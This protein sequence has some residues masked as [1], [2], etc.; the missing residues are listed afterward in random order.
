MKKLKN[1]QLRVEKKKV[2]LHFYILSRLIEMCSFCYVT[3]Q[4]TAMEDFELPASGYLERFGFTDHNYH[5]LNNKEQ[6]GA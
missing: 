1:L 5:D 3:T 4:L 2:N 6:P